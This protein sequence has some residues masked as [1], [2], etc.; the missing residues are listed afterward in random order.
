MIWDAIN[1]LIPSSTCVH[2]TAV[3][4]KSINANDYF[5]FYYFI[6]NILYDVY[7]LS[8]LLGKR[9]TTNYNWYFFTVIGPREFEKSLLLYGCIS[10]DPVC[11]L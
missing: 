6:V 10:A 4:L 2:S 1:P 3:R 11:A 7:H 8:S 5:L 9:S